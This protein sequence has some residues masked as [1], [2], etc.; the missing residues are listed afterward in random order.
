[1]IIKKRASLTRSTPNFIIYDKD[2]YDV[3][4]I[5]DLQLEMLC[6]NLLYQAN[7]NDKLKKLFKIVMSQ[8]QKRIWTSKCPGDFNLS[9]KTNNNWCIAAI[10]IF[11]NENIKICDHELY[12]NINKNHLIEGG[13]IDILEILDEKNIMKSAASRKNK[14]I[15]FI[16]D[17]LESDGIYMKKWKHMCKELG[18][19]TKGKVPLWFKE[20]ELK[21]LENTNENTRKIKNEYMRTIDKK[22]IHIKYFDEDKKQDKNTI[23]SWNEEGELPVFAED[24]KRSRSK[25]Y[26]R[27][28]IHYVIKGDNE[29][30]NNS[31]NLTICEGCEKNISKKASSNQCLIYIENKHSRIIDT[32]KEEDTIK[33][34]ETLNNLIKKNECVKIIN[35]EETM[36]EEINERIENID[37][38]IKADKEFITIMKNSLSEYD[39]KERIKKYFLIIDLKKIKND[40]NKHGKRTYFYN[41]VWILK[42]NNVQKE[43]EIFFSASYE[44]LNENEYKILIRAIIIGL[45]L[46]NQNSKIVLGINKAINKLIKDFIINSKRKKIDSDY[47]IE[48]L[49]IEHFLFKNNIKIVDALDDEMHTIT[50]IK[51]RIDKTLLG[52]FKEKKMR[53][54]IDI[55]DNALL[56]NEYN[57]IWKKNIIT[58]GF[59]KWR[60]NVSMALWKNEILNSNKLNDL[61]MY[62]FKKEFDW[63]TT[64]EFISN[65][66]TFS[67][68]Q[69]SIEDTRERSYRI[70]NLIKELPT[71]E[72]LFKRD[73][74]CIEDNLCMRCGKKESETWDHMWVCEDNEATLEE[75]ARESISKFE[76]FLKDNDRI[77]DISILRDHNVNIITILEEPSNILLKKCRIWE[78]L[79]GVFNDKFNKLTN[80]KGERCIIKECWNFIYNEFKN[81]IWQPRCDEIARLEQIM[82]IQKQDLKRKRKQERKAKEDSID[83]KII[84]NI[85]KKTDKNNEK[86]TKNNNNNFDKNI[87]IVTRDR[88]IGSITDGIH[89]K[90]IWDSTTKTF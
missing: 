11:N 27:I 89:I 64:L 23:V 77:E 88:L 72:T 83:E 67:K 19:S 25:N 39:T 14:K 63:R 62:N 90:K 81:R 47:Y 55:S 30:W 44:V 35:E 79:R 36:N 80:I 33:P 7:G 41:I 75:I 6:K 10:K 78:M 34:F 17:V 71:Y 32:R 16:E 22:N 28:G 61:F 38:I 84:N 82:G 70:K 48:L 54:Q 60:K 5:Y 85:N 50:E 69:C 13:N 40:L 12:S 31:P 24:K 2:L 53:Y 26:K 65:R 59:R 42:E 66:T 51:N 45:I 52:D 18:V 86:K 1:M 56:V 46:I 20:L 15:M 49:Y 87:N 57:L 68:R 74:N 58:G 3:K 76:E 9:Y 29:G 21:I 73:V 43:E 8:E 4:H 37:S